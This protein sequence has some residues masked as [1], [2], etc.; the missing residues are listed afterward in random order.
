M[1]DQKEEILLGQLRKHGAVFIENLYD[2]EDL[3]VVN[4]KID[5]YFLDRQ[6]KERAYVTANEL[7]ELNLLDKLIPTAL[8]NLF[9]QLL[10]QVDVYHCHVYETA[11]GKNKSHI[12]GDRLD[13]WHR[14]I[15]CDTSDAKLNE[16]LSLFLYLS[17]VNQGDGGFEIVPADHV[18]KTPDGQLSKTM[19]GPVGTVL[20]WNRTLWH[21]ATPNQGST[22]RR[23]FKIS[24]QPINR[25]NPF[26][27]SEEGKHL[28]EK[29]FETKNVRANLFG[30][31]VGQSQ[32]ESALNI[33]TKP[34][35]GDSAVHLNFWPRLKNRL[36]EVLGK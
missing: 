28:R 10:N 2:E 31:N 9:E 8:V 30:M 36:L 34:C 21:R 25:E 17:P 3:R 12:R 23:V 19:V 1:V 11:A 6:E 4:S 15:D 29:L 16:C 27:N 33:K 7:L 22:R 35:L 18:S 24:I 5:S 26:R 32:D 20:L 13:G 14:D